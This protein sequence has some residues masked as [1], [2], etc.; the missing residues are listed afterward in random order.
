MLCKRGE[1]IESLSL[2]YLV[3]LGSAALE[4]FQTMI[5]RRQVLS[6]FIALVFLA[7]IGL[8]VAALI[9][10]KDGP[11]TIYDSNGATPEYRIK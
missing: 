10:G 11:W 9:M 8:S 2:D 7:T 1:Y 4:L 5:L 6:I 3:C